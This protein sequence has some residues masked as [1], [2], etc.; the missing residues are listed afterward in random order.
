MGENMGAKKK[1]LK[2]ESITLRV[3]EDEVGYIDGL[4]ELVEEELNIKTTR[5]WVIGRLIML[6]GE[7][8]EKEYGLKIKKKNKK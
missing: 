4:L 1:T 8:F 6:G 2:T 5:T 3:T 7:N